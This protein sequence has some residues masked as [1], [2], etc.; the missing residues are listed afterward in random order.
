[1]DA[2]PWAELERNLAIHIYI[3]VD[4]AFVQELK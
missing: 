3:N 1:M 2:S 4:D